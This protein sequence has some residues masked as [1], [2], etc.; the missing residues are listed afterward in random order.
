MRGHHPLISASGT[1]GSTMSAPSNALARARSTA[2]TTRTNCR[3]VNSTTNPISASGINPTPRETPVTMIVNQAIPRGRSMRRWS[4]SFQ[5]RAR[6]RGR[7]RRSMISDPP[8]PAPELA[9]EPRDAAVRPAGGAGSGR[10]S[11][12]ATSWR[13]RAAPSS[14]APA[15]SARWSRRWRPRPP[16]ETDQLQRPDVATDEAAEHAHH[17][18]GGGGDD[19]GGRRQASATALGVVAGA[20][21]L[22]PDR[23]SRNTS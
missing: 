16:A 2:D 1:N 12:A 11:G 15:R 22:L 13:C 20:V 10:A 19:P 21:V 8:R 23:A 4:V 14:R 5:V 3:V 7:N 17:D 9:R 18:R 6:T